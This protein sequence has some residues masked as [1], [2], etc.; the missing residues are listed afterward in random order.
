M[1]KGETLDVVVWNKQYF[2][3]VLVCMFLLH[4]SGWRHKGLRVRGQG[5]ISELPGLMAWKIPLQEGEGHA[6]PAF[7]LQKALPLAFQPRP[8]CG[9]RVKAMCPFSF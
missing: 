8:F 1:G 7:P 6:R 5:G 2:S 4:L 3:F 9:S